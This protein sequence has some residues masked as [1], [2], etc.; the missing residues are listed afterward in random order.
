MGDQSHKLVP[1]LHLPVQSGSN[2]ILELM[3]RR[4][5]ALDYARE[6]EEAI[7]GNPRPPAWAQMSWWDF[8]V[9]V[10]WSLQQKH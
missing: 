8:P 7:L 1:F 6:V 4:Y 3:K 9:K 10:S 5:N 2:R